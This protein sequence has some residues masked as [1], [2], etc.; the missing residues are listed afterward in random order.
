MDDEVGYVTLHVENEIDESVSISD[1]KGNDSAQEQQEEPK[2]L[3]TEDK[4]II[5]TNLHN[6]NEASNLQNGNTGLPFQGE[7]EKDEKKIHKIKSYICPMV[8]YSIL[9][10]I[11][12]PLL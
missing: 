3:T 9:Q 12:I 6:E 5:L 10:F 2:D 8:T 11:M 4:V 7:D 1:R